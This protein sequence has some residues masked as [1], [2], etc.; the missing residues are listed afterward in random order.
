M[1]MGKEDRPTSA[2]RGFGSYR[3]VHA[4]GYAAGG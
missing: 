3:W 4:D 1:V 2:S